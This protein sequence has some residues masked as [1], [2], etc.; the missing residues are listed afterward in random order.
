MLDDNQII[1]QIEEDYLDDDFDLW[2][3]VSQIL[4]TI[5]LNLIHIDLNLIS[6]DLQYII[7]YQHKISCF[8]E[9]LRKIS[10]IYITQFYSIYF[11]L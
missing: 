4:F 5:D 10:P 9:L 3:T 11:Y 7:F 2:S 1:N 6:M 8:I